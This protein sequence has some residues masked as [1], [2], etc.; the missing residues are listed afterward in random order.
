MR[1]MSNFIG[2]NLNFLSIGN[3]CELL[4]LRGPNQRHPYSRYWL[5]TLF[6]MISQLSK[7]CPNYKRSNGIMK[8][9]SLPSAAC[10]TNSIVTVTPVDF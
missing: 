7:L 2:F 10:K 6:P 4:L 9:C 8:R 3:Q 1:T 5:I